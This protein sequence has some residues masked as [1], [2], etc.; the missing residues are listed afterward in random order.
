MST[1]RDIAGDD[2]GTFEPVL[3]NGYYRDGY[4]IENAQVKT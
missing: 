2:K 4:V 3:S 1:K